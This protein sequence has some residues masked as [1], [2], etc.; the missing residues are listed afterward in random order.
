MKWIRFI[1]LH[2][3]TGLLGTTPVCHLTMCWRM[4][5]CFLASYKARLTRTRAS[6]K[7]RS[8]RDSWLTELNSSAERILL[9][10]EHKAL[11]HKFI[12]A[13]FLLHNECFTSPDLSTSSLCR[14]QS[15]WRVSAW[16]RKQ[17]LTHRFLI[18]YQLKTLLLFGFY[19]VFPSV[20]MKTDTPTNF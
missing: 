7:T 6:L 3:H 17:K 4:P 11:P 18:Y 16:Q 14:R 12:A 1:T 19:L 8:R 13:L 2:Y 20:W 15:K 10:G 9:C 5:S